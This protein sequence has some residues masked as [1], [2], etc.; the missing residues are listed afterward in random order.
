LVTILASR[1]H[2]SAAL[3]AFS[4]AFVLGLISILPT[5]GYTQYFCLCVPFLIVAAV[6][7]A[8]NY[9]TSLPGGQPKCIAAV[10]SIALL[11]IF[12]SSS[13]PSFRRYLITG[14]R[15]PGIKDACDAPNWTMDKVSEVSN[16]IDQLAAPNEQIVSFWPGYIFA[17]KADSYPG[18]ENDFSWI[19]TNKL[20][21]DQRAKYHIPARTDIEADLATHATRIAVVGNQWS[22]ARAIWGSSSECARMLSANGY[23]AARTIGD[24]SIFVCCSKQ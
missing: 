24:T 9:I 1:A 22:A 6:N 4:I 20:T 16:A 5:P 15:V 11:V 10:A 8:S 17:T 14:D 19:V 3:L 7:G 23:T 2:K 13:V 18:L 12:V 21:F